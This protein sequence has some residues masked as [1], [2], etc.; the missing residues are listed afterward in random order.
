MRFGLWIQNTTVPTPSAWN[1]KIFTTN[2][3]WNFES[4]SSGKGRTILSLF[5]LF[6][7]TKSAK[8]YLKLNKPKKRVAGTC[9]RN[10]EIK[11]KRKLKRI[12]QCKISKTTVTRHNITMSLFI[13]ILNSRGLANSQCFTASFPLLTVTGR[14]RSGLWTRQVS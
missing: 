2:N 8:I 12:H 1:T 6:K 4:P 13:W 10:Y 5:L 14:R 3:T 7:L 9:T 11:I